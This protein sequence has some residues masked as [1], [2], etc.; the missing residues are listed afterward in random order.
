[1]RVVKLV[2]ALSAVLAFTV[3]GVAS[4]SAAETLWQWLPG[5]EKTAFTGSTGEVIFET[6][7][8]ASFKCKASTVTGELTTEKT[9]GLFLVTLTGCKSF[10]FPANSLGDA[11]ETI[12]MHV[13]VHN[14]TIKAGEAGLLLKF[15]PVHIEIPTLSLLLDLEGA[16]IAGLTPNN[17]L[18]KAYTLTIAEKGGKQ[19]IEKCE[20]GVKQTLKSSTDS[21][22]F[23]ELGVEASKGTLTF[24]TV[25]Q[26]AM[27]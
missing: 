23:E 27:A 26:E 13:E 21:K 5:A 17:T 3:L 8:K 19:S 9:L 2:L 14:C 11:A 10:G 1:M 12:L 7:A 24:T 22:A 25:A 6:V 18:T 15:L 20:G 16:F 4:A